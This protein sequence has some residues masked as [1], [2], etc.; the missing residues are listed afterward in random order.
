PCPA[1]PRPSAWPGRRVRVD[2]AVADGSGCE[3]P[4]RTGP[5]WPVTEY[6]NVISLST[7][8]TST[9]T[10]TTVCSIQRARNGS[11]TIASTA[12]STW[13][14]TRTGIVTTSAVVTA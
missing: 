8:G 12:W 9:K 1:S 6:A 7:T 13:C 4:G 14:S 3:D 10:A 5:A 2:H 11:S